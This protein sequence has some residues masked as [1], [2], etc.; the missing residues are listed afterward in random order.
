MSLT[1]MAEIC[2]KQGEQE[3]LKMAGDLYNR[4][5]TI[6]SELAE[7]LKSIQSYTDLIIGLCHVAC[8]PMTEPDVSRQ[9]LE[10]I[11]SISE[12]LYRQTQSPRYRQ[13]IELA[14]TMLAGL[15]PYL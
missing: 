8:H 12:R 6:Q 11:L 13:F 7:E 15:Q 1:K 4:S 2:E 5:L 10:Q 9:Y 3:N 14:K